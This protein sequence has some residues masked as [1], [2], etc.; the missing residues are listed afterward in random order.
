VTR[1][2]VLPDFRIECYQKLLALYGIQWS[3]SVLIT[4]SFHTNL[5]QFNEIHTIMS[6]FF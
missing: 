1:E 6:Y 5:N 4:L 3:I 2:M